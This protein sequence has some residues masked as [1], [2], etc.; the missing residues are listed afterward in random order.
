MPAYFVAGPRQS[1]SSSGLRQKISFEASEFRPPSAVADG[2]DEHLARFASCQLHFD[3]LAGAGQRGRRV[4]GW[5]PL[6]ARHQAATDRFL[7]FQQCAGARVRD[8]SLNTCGLS[9][10]TSLGPAISSCSF[11]SCTSTTP[12]S[13]RERRSTKRPIRAAGFHVER[14]EFPAF[15]RHD[16][17]AAEFATAAGLRVAPSCDG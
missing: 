4:D 1:T 5:S 12:A 2:F 8:V 7:R 10:R 6:P 15:R 3:R 13:R 11:A 9:N 17:P 14:A 16:V